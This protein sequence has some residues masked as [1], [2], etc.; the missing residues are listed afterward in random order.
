MGQVGGDSTAACI[1]RGAVASAASERAARASTL[2]VVGA[3]RVQPIDVTRWDAHAR[4]NPAAPQERWFMQ[5]E[6]A[7]AQHRSDRQHP[8]RASRA[9]DGGARSSDTQ[10]APGRAVTPD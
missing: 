7:P 3:A 9:L 6:L 10:A 5:I 1:L 4:I 2:L 8:A